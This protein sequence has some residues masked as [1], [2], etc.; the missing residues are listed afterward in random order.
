ML[1]RKDRDLRL[2]TIWKCEAGGFAPAFGPH[3]ESTR[4]FKLWLS[5]FTWYA[6]RLEEKDG[7]LATPALAKQPTPRRPAPQWPTGSPGDYRDSCHRVGCRGIAQPRGSAAN[8]SPLR[9]Q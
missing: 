5:A 4:G 3:R 9:R 8:R 7:W 2:A 1:Q 6:E